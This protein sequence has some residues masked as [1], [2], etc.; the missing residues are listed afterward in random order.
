MLGS[1][2]PL[3]FGYS[4][5]WSSNYHS[6]CCLKVAKA[7]DVRQPKLSPRQRGTHTHQQQQQQQQQQDDD[8]RRVIETIILSG[9]SAIITTAAT[10]FFGAELGVPYPEEAYAAAVEEEGTQQLPYNSLLTEISDPNSYTALA[11]GPPPSSSSSS[12][13]KSLP[14]L[15]L[16]L[17]GAGK[18]DLNIWDDLASPNGEHRGLIPSLIESGNAPNELLQNFAILAPYSKGQDSFYQDSRSKLLGFVNWATANQNTPQCPS[19]FDP[20]RIWIFGFSDGATVAIELMTTKKFV[21]GI[22]CSYGFSGKSLPPTALQRLANLPMSVFHSADDVIFDV[23]NSDRLV[24]QLR[25][26]S[27]TANDDS[28]IKYYRYKQDP[29]KDLVPAS[30]RGHVSM[31]IVASKMPELYDWMLSKSTQLN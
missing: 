31:A 14:P 11:Y 19:A 26:V 25:S 15:I 18:N 5:L 2:V 23:K 22:I 29:E 10:L 28:V 6:G 24:E 3:F 1:K 20:S 27:T 16:V 12:S 21:G 30:V 9:G 4:V 8:R 7:W 17:H 13:S